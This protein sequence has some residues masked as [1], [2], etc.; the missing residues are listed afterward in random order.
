MT[1]APHTNPWGPRFREADFFGSRLFFWGCVNDAKLV[2]NFVRRLILRRKPGFF[3]QFG[4]VGGTN[5]RAFSGAGFRRE[6]GGG[7]REQGRQRLKSG[8]AFHVLGDVPSMAGEHA[9]G[10]GRTRN[11]VDRRW[12]KYA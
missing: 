1:Y 9:A 6:S 10:R 11:S 12:R 3:D 2:V 7:G 5:F 4:T 8:G